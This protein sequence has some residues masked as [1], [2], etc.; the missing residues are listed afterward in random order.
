MFR[1]STCCSLGWLNIETSFCPNLAIFYKNLKKQYLEELKG[2]FTLQHSHGIETGNNAKM[3]MV[4]IRLDI[5]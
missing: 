3:S 1:I 5:P 2:P 4:E